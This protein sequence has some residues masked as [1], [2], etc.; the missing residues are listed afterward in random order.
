MAAASPPSA[1]GND[2]V[3]VLNPSTHTA[4]LSLEPDE[5]VT[6]HL[7]PQT[8]DDI[9]YRC[10]VCLEAFS[11]MLPPYLT[12]CGH[13]LCSKC[14]DHLLNTSTTECPQCRDP[15]GLNNARCDKHY[16]RMVKSLQVRCSEYKEGCGWV[17]QLKDLHD[18]QC[19]IACPYGCSKYARSSV[20][21]EHTRHCHNRMISCENCGYYD[22]LTIVTEQHYPVCPQS[23]QTAITPATVSPQYLYNQAPI[24]FIIGDFSEKKR[25]NEEWLGSPFYT[26]NRGYKFRLNV[27]PNGIGNGSGSHLSVHAEPVRGEYDDEIFEVDIQIELLNWREDKNHHSATICFNRHDHT[28][29]RIT[30]QDTA[31]RLGQLHQFI[32]HT[33]L[34]PTDNTR[35]LHGDFIKLRVNVAVYSTPYRPLTPSW[36]PIMIGPGERELAILP[37][38]DD[39]AQPVIAQFTISEFSER[40]EFNNMYFSPPFT[41]SPQ[42][43]KFSIKAMANGCKSGKGTNITISAIIMKGQHDDHLKW[44]FTGTIVIEILNWREDKGHFKQVYS[45]D[46][47][48]KL[49]RVTEGE[50]GKDF[51]FF[52]FISHAALPFDSSTNTQY[53]K[54]DCICVRVR[55][56]RADDD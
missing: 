37:S 43:Y 38:H 33:H 48:D 42:G 32:S 12:D 35:Y 28:V 36:Q 19:G 26:H 18:H 30:S 34:E 21:K 47:N 7:V 13:H 17:G 23:T 15:K 51:G 25:A 49:K 4:L 3:P 16:L 5:S 20:M 2:N 24:E 29:Y 54:D 55:K 53:L 11:D 22:T 41:T 14:C 56:S 44:P 8:T 46:P 10:P 50:Y 9:E 27:Y 45:I 39:S 52:K 31:T 40:K 6:I 1:I